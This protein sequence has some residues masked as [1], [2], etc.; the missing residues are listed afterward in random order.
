MDADENGIALR[1][2][3]CD[4]LIERNENIARACHH[5]FQLR[6]VQFAIQAARHVERDGF[7]GWA[8]AAIRAAILTSVSRVNR[9]R[10]ECPARILGDGS[11]SHQETDQAE[12]KSEA[13]KSQHSLWINEDGRS[14]KFFG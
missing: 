14:A 11:T 1:V 9:Y 5:S 6:F 12:R 4:S 10:L 13:N 2:A 7:F 8:V 3:D